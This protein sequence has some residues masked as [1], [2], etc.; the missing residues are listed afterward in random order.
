MGQPRRTGGGHAQS[1]RGSRRSRSCV[2]WHEARVARRVVAPSLSQRSSERDALPRRQHRRAG[3][4]PALPGAQQGVARA[5]GAS[6]GDRVRRADEAARHATGRHPL[7]AGGAAPPG[8]VGVQEVRPRQDADLVPRARRGHR[9]PSLR[10][11]V[12]VAASSTSTAS[13]SRR[14]RS[15]AHLRASVRRGRRRLAADSLRAAGA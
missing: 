11:R 2:I 5:P 6:L 9:R 3:D 13:A 15:S 1:S 14:S 12:P 10:C 4:A 8:G 7:P